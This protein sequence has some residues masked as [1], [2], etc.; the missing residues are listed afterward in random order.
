[1]ALSF[2]L[3]LSMKGWKTHQK[4]ERARPG[5]FVQNILVAGQLEHLIARPG[6]HLINLSL[7][8]CSFY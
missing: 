8:S 1:M 3:T 6:F 7:L 2:I 4:A 5:E